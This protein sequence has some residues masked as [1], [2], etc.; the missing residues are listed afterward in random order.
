MGFVTKVDLS[1]NRQIKELPRTTSILSGATQ[2]GIPFSA[3]TSGPD[4][5][6]ETIYASATTLVS[7]FVG[8]SA[9]TTYTWADP[10][11]SMGESV[12]SAITPA[13][14]A[15]TQDTDSV[16]TAQ[17]TTTID[18]NTVVLTYTGV[19]FDL[20]VNN[21]IELAPNSY[22]GEVTTYVLDFIS[23]GTLDYTGR[24]I[25]SDTKGISRTEKLIVSDNPTIGYVLTCA[26]SEG[27]TTWG[28]TTNVIEGIVE[29]TTDYSA[30]TS[31]T[32]IFVD[33]SSNDVTVYLPDATLTSGKKFTVKNVSNS[34][35]VVT[36]SANL[37]SQNID[38][39][40]TEGVSYLDAITVISNGANWWII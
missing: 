28:P 5:S 9:S 10:I 40:S 36:L 26:N 6:T 20:Y 24:T 1:Y 14:S 34:D 8:T 11:M 27:M 37:Y 18:G 2:F 33:S 7:T 22:S 35:Y 38:D 16:Y 39:A 21:M 29:V 30:A 15:T 32:T 3:M 4:Y 19:S 13:N 17:T 12:L 25:W 23:A 31:A